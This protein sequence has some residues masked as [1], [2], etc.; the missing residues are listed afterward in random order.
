M[1]E[2]AGFL[3]FLLLIGMATIQLGLV[4]YAA[5][6][7]GSAARAAARAESLTPGTAQTAAT[8]S[9]SS[10]LNPQASGGRTGDTVTCT[11]TVR[12][13]PVIPLFD[14]WDLSRTATMPNDD[15]NEGS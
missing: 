4:G 12:V 3:P 1:L 2:F 10:W 5:N 15:E 8:A 14:G 7:A 11:V 13:P 6:Q 9:A